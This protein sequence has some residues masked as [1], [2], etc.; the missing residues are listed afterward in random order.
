MTDA[1][2][3]ANS[4]VVRAAIEGIL[5]VAITLVLMAVLFLVASVFETVDIHPSRF[6]ALALWAVAIIAGSIMTAGRSRGMRYSIE[7][8]LT[9]VAVAG[10][11]VLYATGVIQPTSA[12]ILVLLKSLFFVAAA[13]ISLALVNSSLRD[14]TPP[15]LSR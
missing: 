5:V 9:I 14:S 12:P 4:S 8:G 13:T 3:P 15:G 10:Y 2:Q 7:L 11:L 6:V 1:G